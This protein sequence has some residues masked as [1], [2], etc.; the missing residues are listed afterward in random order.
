MLKLSVVS[1]GSKSA[2]LG[3]VV[4]RIPIGFDGAGTPNKFTNLL[5]EYSS[6][7]FERLVREAHKRFST[8]IA[9]SDEL[10]P[11]PY[12]LKAL[13]PAS[14]DTDKATFYPRVNSQ[15]NMELLKNILNNTDYSKFILKQSAFTFQDNSTGIGLI[16]GSCLTK[17]L[18]NRVD[19]NLVVDVKVLR[20]QLENVKLHT[21]KNNVDLMLMDMEE[22][23]FGLLCK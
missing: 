18:M 1:C 7:S 8:E 11:P 16:D 23:Y 10:P 14:S 4:T 21:F 19:P 9:E 17:V 15:V 6:I 2:T 5:T 12:T 22:N 3:E 20:Q 13:D